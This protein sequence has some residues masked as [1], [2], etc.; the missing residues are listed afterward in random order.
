MTGKAGWANGRAK[1]GRRSIACASCGDATSPRGDLAYTVVE[2]TGYPVA[3]GHVGGGNGTCYREA[4]GGGAGLEDEGWSLSSGED[5]RL[6]AFIYRCYAA[7]RLYGWAD[8][9]AVSREDC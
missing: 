4:G 3:E 5:S 8:G 1:S 6:R 2:A 7:N 9:G